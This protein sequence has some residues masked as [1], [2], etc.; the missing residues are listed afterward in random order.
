M[1]IGEAPGKDEDET[2][3]PFVGRAGKILDKAIADTGLTEK[4]FIIVNV[5][6]CRPA[7]NKYMKIYEKN[8]ISYL[9]TQIEI[10]SPKLIV[11][12]GMHALAIFSKEKLIKNIGIPIRHQEYTVIPMLHPASVLHDPRKWNLWND[13]WNALKTYIEHK[14]IINEK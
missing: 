2:G 3:V 13:S 4:D 7:G 1:F 11:T 10:I 6:K 8:C 9:N 14:K 5:L 12:L